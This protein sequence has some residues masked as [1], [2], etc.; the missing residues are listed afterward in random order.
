[1]P[2]EREIFALELRMLNLNH[3][4]TEGK[5]AMNVSCMFLPIKIMLSNKLWFTLDKFC[6]IISKISIFVYSTVLYHLVLL[7]A[8]LSGLSL[9][10]SI[11]M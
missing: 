10:N 8:G 9:Q 7:Y 5:K 6:P 4:G 3:L 11:L 1:M 2:T